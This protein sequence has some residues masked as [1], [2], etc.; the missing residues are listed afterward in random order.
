MH[1]TSA[2]ELELTPDLLEYAKAVA[3]NEAQKRCPGH[4][5]Y[6]DVVQDALLHLIS[7]PPK[8]DPARG[9]SPRTLIYTIVQRSVLKYIGRECRH[10]NR[11]AQ[12]AEPSDAPS[13]LTPGPTEEQIR[14]HQH[15]TGSGPT[16]HET[17]QSAVDEMLCHIDNEDSRA[18][19]RLFMECNGNVSETARR[20]KLPEATVRYRLKNVLGPKL[21]AAGYSPFS[22]GEMQ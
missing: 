7:K 11:F 19:C 6:G 8:Y 12:F 13:E 17:L 22:C 20:M 10:A 1:A 3:L 4:V 2:P 16:Q 5:D 18:L 14:T 9:A 15:L 21:V